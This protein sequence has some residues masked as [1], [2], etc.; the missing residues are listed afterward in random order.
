MAGD[1]SAVRPGTT[2]APAAASGGGGAGVANSEATEQIRSALG[3]FTLP[4]DYEL[5]PLPDGSDTQACRLGGGLQEEGVVVGQTAGA[6][7]RRRV[8]P[9]GT[10]QKDVP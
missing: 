5:V 2:T 4:S 7:F 8:A 6:R 3:P 9:R 1:T 10:F